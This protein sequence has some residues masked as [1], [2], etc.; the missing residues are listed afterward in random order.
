MQTDVVAPAAIDDLVHH[1]AGLAIG[2]RNEGDDPAQ[3]YQLASLTGLT[4]NDQ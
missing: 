3:R 1:A 4:E 2:G